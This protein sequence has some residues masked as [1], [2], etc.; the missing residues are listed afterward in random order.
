VPEGMTITFSNLLEISLIRCRWPRWIG[1]NVPPTMAN[2]LV[3]AAIINPGQYAKLDIE[4][5]IRFQR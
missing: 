1:S 3:T 4:A 5:K 2:S